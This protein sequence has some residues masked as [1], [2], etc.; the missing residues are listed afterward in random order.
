MKE[1]DKKENKE[2]LTWIDN[3]HST[4]LYKDK[5]DSI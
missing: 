1:I 4:N 3:T 2:Y 5:S